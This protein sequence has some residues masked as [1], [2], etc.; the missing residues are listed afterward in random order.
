MTLLD[1][2]KDAY[3]SCEDKIERSEFSC[4]CSDY[5]FSVHL[6]DRISD[7][8]S[9]HSQ[10]LTPEQVVEWMGLEWDEPNTNYYEK[11]GFKDIAYISLHLIGLRWYVCIQKDA[12]AE[13]GSED[14]P[15]SRFRNLDELKS[16]VRILTGEEV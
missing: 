1:E 9:K 4:N 11:G 12:D 2:L 10:P 3:R 7:I 16:F 13:F 14:Y 6:S 15:L 5:I 8:I